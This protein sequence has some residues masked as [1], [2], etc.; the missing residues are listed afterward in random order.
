MRPSPH[1][2]LQFLVCAR[3]G[4]AFFCQALSFDLDA[5]RNDLQNDDPKIRT[6]ALGY[7]S[8]Y[9]KAKERGLID[10]AFVESVL[11]SGARA[12]T[13]CESPKFCALR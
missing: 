6:T 11:S 5:L 8:R 12:R 4:P 10:E 7:I 1:V 13:R 9:G 3:G 2:D